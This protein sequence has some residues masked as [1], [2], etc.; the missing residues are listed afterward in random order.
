MNVE[1]DIVTLA[2]SFLDETLRGRLTESE[3]LA[4]ESWLS[5][6]LES[7]RKGWKQKMQLS[8]NEIERE[9]KTALEAHA[10]IQ[11][12][13]TKVEN[14]VED[15]F[16]N[17]QE[18]EYIPADYDLK[19]KHV[20]LLEQSIDA[21][22]SNLVILQ[23]ERHECLKI[24]DI[25]PESGASLIGVLS[26]HITKLK[27][28]AHLN[29]IAKEDNESSLEDQIDILQNELRILE[30]RNN[31]NENVHQKT[32]QSL[33]KKFSDERY[34]QRL[35]ANSASDKSVQVD[36]SETSPR[37]RRQSCSSISED[38]QHK[39]EQRDIKKPAVRS[40]GID[41]QTLIKTCDSA[42]QVPVP[43]HVEAGAVVPYVSDVTYG[44]S[45]DNGASDTSSE[46]SNPSRASEE[47]KQKRK[48]IAMSTIRN[49]Y[50]GFSSKSSPTKKTE[51]EIRKNYLYKA[52]SEGNIH[53]LKSEEARYYDGYLSGVRKEILT[54]NT[55]RASDLV[56]MKHNGIRKSYQPNSHH[57]SSPRTSPKSNSHRCLR[58]HKLY[59][60]RDNHKMACR[61]H[62]KGK[63]KLER[64]DARGRLTMVTYIWECCMQRPE[65]PGCSTGEHI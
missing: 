8:L 12:L 50:M 37:K 43:E 5:G 44:V 49:Q 54:G 59:N 11:D 7:E 23:Q 3:K 27:D 53:K 34:V 40:I 24:L 36:T 63:R 35:N 4:I 28:E 42:T 61:F 47:P 65:A 9:R 22:V 55:I 60:L 38:E 30:E 14:V 13:N 46:H 51:K 1:Q 25:I 48:A 58:C 31:E 29:V 52:Q 18:S 57:D 17:I 32:I 21:I 16:I 45:Y 15:L 10:A 2:G 19:T 20:Y 41:T 26:K 64:Y 33:C 6:Q 62:P 39:G 56:Y